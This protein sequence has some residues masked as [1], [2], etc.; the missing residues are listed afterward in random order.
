M[1]K[2]PNYRKVFPQFD[3]YEKPED[4]FIECK[5]NTGAFTLKGSKAGRSLYI[6]NKETPLDGTRYNYQFFD[7]V[8]QSKE[9]YNMQQHLKSVTQE[10]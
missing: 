8:T 2:S 7:D 4:M 1:M 10:L 5:S 6:A 9:K 3:K